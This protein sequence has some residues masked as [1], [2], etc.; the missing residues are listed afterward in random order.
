M[1]VGLLPLRLALL[2][3]IVSRLKQ[4]GGFQSAR[5]EC[6]ADDPGQVGQLGGRS[7]EGV[8]QRVGIAGHLYPA[9]HASSPLLQARQQYVLQLVACAGIAGRI[10]RE[11]G[12][13]Q[14]HD[15]DSG[16]S[17]HDNG[18]VLCGG[19][20]RGLERIRRQ[21]PGEEKRKQHYSR[22]SS[23]AMKG[24]GSTRWPCTSTS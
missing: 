9:T 4:L 1:C 22:I 12:H 2:V 20:I 3:Q 6:S 8:H 5:S 23:A 19:Y 14:R 21:R 17:V 10:I 18:Y 7:R 13:P 15:G 11:Q 16:L 24:T